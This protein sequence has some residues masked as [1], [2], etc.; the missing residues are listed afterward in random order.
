MNQGRSEPLKEKARRL[1]FQQTVQ[2]NPAAAIPEFLAHF[3]FRGGKTKLHRALP[4]WVVEHL[5]DCF[6]SYWKYGG[7]LDEAFSLKAKERGG[8][9]A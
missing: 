8:E 3:G 5:A 7:S 4:S 2:A 9:N 6:K 1:F